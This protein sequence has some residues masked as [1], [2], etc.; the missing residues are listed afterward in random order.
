[1]AYADPTEDNPTPGYIR[2][3]LALAVLLLPLCVVA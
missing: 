3:L 1:M 2:I